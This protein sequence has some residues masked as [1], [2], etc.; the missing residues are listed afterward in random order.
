MLKVGAGAFVSSMRKASSALKG[1]AAEAVHVSGVTGLMGSVLGALSIGG[2][3]AFT[4][5]TVD[6]AFE[7]AQMVRTSNATYQS[8]AALEH[9]MKLVGGSTADVHRGLDRL[10]KLLSGVGDES[11]YFKAQIEG[12]GLSFEEMA[13]GKLDLDKLKKLADAFQRINDP[14]KRAGVAAL[15]FGDNA[16]KWAQ[17]LDKGAAGMDR[18]AGQAKKLGTELDDIDASTI[19][20]AHD[21]LVGADQIMTGISRQSA[22][23]LS[24]SII[25]ISDKISDLTANV[26]DMATLVKA[27]FRGI[28]TAGAYTWDN[29]KV[30]SVGFV[31]AVLIGL[32]KIAEWTGRT[33]Q[34]ILEK[35]AALPN[36][37][38]G[39]MSDM[40]AQAAAAFKRSAD[41]AEQR[42][43]NLVRET[44]DLLT[45]QGT[46][47]QVEAFFDSMEHGAKRTE[48][49]MKAMGNEAARGARGAVQAIGRFGDAM[50]GNAHIFAELSSNTDKLKAKFADLAV[51]VKTSTDP[52]RMNKFARGMAGVVDEMEKAAGLDKVQLAGGLRRESAEA[53]S[54]VN[55]QDALVNLRFRQT[56]QQRVESVLKQIAEMD[57]QKL[58]VAKATLAAL[59]KQPQLVPM[60]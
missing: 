25:T 17:I 3:V 31:N 29:L 19:E 56:P 27:A 35:F 24:D 40:A 41:D 18:L 16:G 52:D 57:R 42:T 39:G 49:A 34:K 9:G 8:F 15:I 46:L 60:P 12:M 10:N 33:F 1:F 45:D 51:F 5:R 20:R 43:K 7:L 13:K 4:K 14:M 21:S 38:T 50:K 32:N 55:Q 6:A 53:L 58:E 23:Q 2:L 54:H 28:A 44:R 37:L 47:P 59:Q 26:G 11:R 22:V 36:A 48:N 30:L